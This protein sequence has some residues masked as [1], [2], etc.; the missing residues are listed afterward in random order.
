MYLFRITTVT[1]GRIVPEVCQAVY[2][3]LED[4]FLKVG[5][6]TT[7]WKVGLLVLGPEANISLIGATSGGKGY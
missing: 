6:R 7:F 2:D 1:I 4:E 3:V 5:V